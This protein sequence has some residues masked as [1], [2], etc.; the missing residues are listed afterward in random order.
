MAKTQITPIIAPSLPIAT[1]DYQ[2]QYFDQYSNVLRLY[3]NQIDNFTRGILIPA[4]GTTSERPT[5][6]LTLGQTYFDTTLNIPI[7]YNG[8]NWVN[9]AGTTV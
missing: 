7:W 5:E 8:T 6:R 1:S 3:F 9:T 4:Y 2:Q